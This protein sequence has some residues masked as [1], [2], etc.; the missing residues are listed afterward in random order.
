LS[1]LPAALVAFILVGAVIGA[2]WTFIHWG[3]WWQR[4]RSHF[5]RHAG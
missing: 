5:V 4:Q 2:A 1:Q 3:R